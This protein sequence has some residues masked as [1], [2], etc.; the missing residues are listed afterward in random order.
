[1]QLV[2]SWDRG[3]NSRGALGPP[4][5]LPPF[6]SVR[7]PASAR[8]ALLAGATQ[9]HLRDRP[10]S[11]PHTQ[12]LPSARGRG[13]SGC[14]LC[15]PRGVCPFRVG[16]APRR[17]PARPGGGADAPGAVCEAA[18]AGRWGSWLWWWVAR[19]GF[20]T[21]DEMRRGVKQ[22]DCVPPW[23]F[24]AGEWRY[25][26]LWSPNG[27]VTMSHRTLKGKTALCK[28]IIYWKQQHCQDNKLYLRQGVAVSFKMDFS[29]PLL[30]DLKN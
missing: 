17:F 19:V 29:S 23:G 1:M 10:T 3:C 21:A 7:L 30:S 2:A 28:C 8:G 11:P 9:Q 5:L 6:S 25:P 15:S 18:A 13:A 27:V 20:G 22:G 26:V 24:V 12:S 4:G 16:A 14:S